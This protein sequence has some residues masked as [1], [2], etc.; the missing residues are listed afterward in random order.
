M[1]ESPST[2]AE[3]W[4]EIQRAI[5][6]VDRMPQDWTECSVAMDVIMTLR[7]IGRFRMV[8][9]FLNSLHLMSV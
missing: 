9:N 5:L 7:V 1:S 8:E 6:G 3:L 2:N 4:L